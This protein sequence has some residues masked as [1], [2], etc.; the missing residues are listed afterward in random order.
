[1]TFGE[2]LA[3]AGPG[4]DF[5]FLGVEADVILISVASYVH[6]GFGRHRLR[7]DIVLL[8]NHAVLLLIDHKLVVLQSLRSHDRLLAVQALLA[9]IAV[10]VLLV[11]ARAHRLRLRG[12][13]GQSGDVPQINLV[14]VLIVRCVAHGSLLAEEGL[15]EGW[16]LLELLHHAVN[17]L[18]SLLIARRIRVLHL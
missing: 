17:L 15:L 8:H 3:G 2:L 6:K 9:P 10:C 11:Q 18:L 12:E 1:M 13:V 5:P 4:L 14:V 7:A 16:V